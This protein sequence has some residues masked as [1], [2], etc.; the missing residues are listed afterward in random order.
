MIALIRRLFGKAGPPSE[1]RAK[2][3][4][5]SSVTFDEDGISTFW[6]GEPHERISW[7]AVLIVVI[8]IKQQGWISVPHWYLS[9]KGAG[10]AFP[11]DAVGHEALVNEFKSR[12]PGYNKVDTYRMIVEAMGADAGSF[13]IWER[14]A[15]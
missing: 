12:F 11:S 13:L 2:Y 9:G 14:E 4:S 7:D 3:V 15:A 5:P 10:I 1:S 6:K 8:E